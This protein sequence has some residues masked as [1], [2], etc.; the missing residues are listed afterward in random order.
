MDGRNKLFCISDMFYTDGYLNAVS[1]SIFW[2]KK[3]FEI[4]EIKMYRNTFQNCMWAY[5][6]QYWIWDTA[7]HWRSAIGIHSGHDPGGFNSH[8][9]STIQSISRLGFNTYRAYIII[10]LCYNV[11]A[12]FL[13]R[14]WWTMMH[15]YYVYTICIM[16]YYYVIWW[17]QM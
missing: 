6:I 8:V 1:H 13:M 2:K 3:C 15:Y 10:I 11:Q 14:T 5:K 4:P 16:L 17:I 7:Q 9:P 12:R